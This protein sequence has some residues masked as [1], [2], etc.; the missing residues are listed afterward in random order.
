MP[1]AGV[2]TRASTP[3]LLVIL[4]GILEDTTMPHRALGLLVT[5]ALSL[6]MAPLGTHAQPSG[7]VYRIG[8]LYS[9]RP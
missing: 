7:K 8:V 4:Q 6:L 5:L 2:Y 9:T 3:L 1:R